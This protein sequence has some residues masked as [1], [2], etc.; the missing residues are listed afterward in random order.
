[1][2]FDCSGYESSGFVF[3][4]GW[5]IQTVA[6]TMYNNV[7]LSQDFV[8]FDEARRVPVMVSNLSS[9]FVEVNK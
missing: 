4:R 5:K 8:E 6:G 2:H 1:M 9:S 3:S 7:D